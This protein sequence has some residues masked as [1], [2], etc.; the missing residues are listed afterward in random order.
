MVNF[1]VNYLENIRN[2]THISG[3]SN[4]KPGY[5]KELLPENAPLE[6]EDWPEIF[7]DI[8]RVIMPGVS[9]IS[10]TCHY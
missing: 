8:E 5:M 7:E 2:Q 1:N 6:G 4:V 10:C 9:K 3:E